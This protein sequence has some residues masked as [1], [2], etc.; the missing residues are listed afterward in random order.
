MTEDFEPMGGMSQYGGSSVTMDPEKR[1]ETIFGELIPRAVVDA[2]RGPCYIAHTCKK[3]L[4]YLKTAEKLAERVDSPKRE[5]MLSK[6]EFYRETIN[7]EIV[8][9]GLLETGELLSYKGKIVRVGKRSGKCHT[10][11][12]L[13]SGKPFRTYGNVRKTDIDN[14]LEE[15][16]DCCEDGAIRIKDCD[17]ETYMLA[18]KNG[19]EI[20]FIKERKASA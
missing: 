5:D 20:H 16:R 2:G 13:E 9:D 6:I 18:A 15:L 17:K 11:E 10:F 7:A 19:L 12:G 8:E 14:L 4:G 3:I 1:I